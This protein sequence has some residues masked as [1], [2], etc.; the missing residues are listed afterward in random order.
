MC[1]LVFEQDRLVLREERDRTLDRLLHRVWDIRLGLYSVDDLLTLASDP[2][3]P[4]HVLT[5]TF[6]GVDV[7][8]EEVGLLRLERRL[9]KPGAHTARPV[10]EAERDAAAAL[11]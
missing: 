3:V 1:P 10:V 11:L 8:A 6:P 2:D 9:G 5:T 7:P 4:A